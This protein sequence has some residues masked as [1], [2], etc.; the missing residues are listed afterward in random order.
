MFIFSSGG[1]DNN[2]NRLNFVN[3]IRAI[4][5]GHQSLIKMGDNKIARA[6][7]EMPDPEPTLSLAAM[8]EKTEDVHTEEPVKPADPKLEYVPQKPNNK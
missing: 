2:Q 5:R 7:A 8:T 1:R 6:P 4:S 3:L